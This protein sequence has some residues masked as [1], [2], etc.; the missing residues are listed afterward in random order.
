MSVSPPSF[1]LVVP[2]LVCPKTL[3][4]H[5]TFATAIGRMAA[6]PG[7]SGSRIAGGTVGGRHHGRNAM[8]GGAATGRRPAPSGSIG[9]YEG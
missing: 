9:H 5:G 2:L 4:Q 7:N 3:E 8:V 1:E 6:R